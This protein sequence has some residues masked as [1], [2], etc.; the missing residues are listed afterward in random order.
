MSELEEN[1]LAAGPILGF[2]GG[3]VILVYGAYEIYVWSVGQSLASLGGLPVG[4]LAGLLAGGVTGVLLGLFTMLASA[5]LWFSPE[6]HTQ[7]G[8][9][10]VTLSFL[11]LVSVGGGD[12]IGMILGVLGGT[13]GV[14]FGPR[15]PELPPVDLPEG[16]PSGSH[17]MPLSPTPDARGRTFKAC[18]SCR[19]VI[20]IQ[21]TKC[22]NCGR[23]VG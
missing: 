21:A 10:I 22:P 7:L 14:V 13:C 11:S 20:P 5:D 1:K 9:V 6:L 18:P 12:G 2:V 15:Y 17:P 23:T 19:Q 16:N 4:S 3:L 8:L